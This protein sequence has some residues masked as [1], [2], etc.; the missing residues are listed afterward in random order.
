MWVGTLRLPDF[1]IAGAPRCATT[2]LAEL[3]ERHPDIAMARPMKPEPKFFLIDD[4]FARGPDHY[5]RTWFTDLPDVARL[6][7]KSTN[8]LESPAAARRIHDTI[9]D[10]KLIFMLRNP[11]DRAYSNYLWTRK[12]G[13]ETKS[14]SE[15]IDLEAERERNL[16]ESLRFA[17]PFSYFSRGLYAD[18][19]LPYFY[20]FPVE[21]IKILR[22]EDVAATPQTVATAFHD[23]L[24]IA[25]RPEDAGS[26]G[27]VNSAVEA[28]SPPLPAA[29]KTVLAERYI[30]PNHRLAKLIGH[31]LWP[32]TP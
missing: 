28:S 8:Y 23:Y 9:P 24:K 25:P 17:K 29:I 1:I 3:A 2:W 27:P 11:V 6:G 13:L 7:E 16:P 19:L 12:N 22:Y 20:R 30:E 10:V 18:L 31:D 4:L 32:I 26:L 15:A 14:F 21:Q 5:S